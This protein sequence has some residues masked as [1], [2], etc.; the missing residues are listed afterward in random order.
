AG[1]LAEQPVHAVLLD[2]SQGDL[3]DARRAVIA[4]HLGPRA[5]QNVTAADLVIQR[6]ESSS[7]IGLGRPVQ[8]MLQGTDRIGRDT[9]ARS[10]SGGTSTDGTHQAPPDN[11]AHRRSSG[12]S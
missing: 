3:V 10:R 6:V 5:P 9:P 12:P 8:R 7:G 11:A 4:A 1:Q 2:A